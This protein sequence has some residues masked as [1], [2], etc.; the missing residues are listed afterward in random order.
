M[1]SLLV[2]SVAL[3]CLML[4]L[5]C[6]SDEP[7]SAAPAFI[8]DAPRSGQ[9][10]TIFLRRRAGAGGGVLVD[11]VAHGIERNVHGVAFRLHWDPAQLGF[12]GAEGSDSWSRQAM[13]LAKE[14]APG[15][16]VVVWTEKGA[17][18]A[19]NAKDETVLGTVELDRRTSGETSLEFRNDRS[20][21]RDERGA[22]LMAEWRGGR[23]GD[24]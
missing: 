9:G 13:F 23:I 10:P 14:G 8:P 2:R 5:G 24:R 7:K 12:S 6:S 21:L 22:P 17:A 15:E 16:L 1:T 11:V 20:T 4:L 3:A 18:P 19:L